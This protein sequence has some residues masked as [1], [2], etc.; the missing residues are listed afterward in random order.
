MKRAI[1]LLLVFTC[2]FSFTSIAYAE[3]TEVLDSATL[4]ESIS[5]DSIK[6]EEVSVSQ[7]VALKKGFSDDVY[8]TNISRNGKFEVT[9]YVDFQEDKIVHEYADGNVVEQRLSDVV[10]ITKTAPSTDDELLISELSS[11][12][13]YASTDYITNEP[14]YVSATGVQ[15]VLSGAAYYSGYRAMGY[16]GGYYY[17]P[18]TYG[19]LQRKN[20]G[21]IGTYYSHLFSFSA[22]TTIGTAASVIVAFFTSSGVSLLLSLATAILGAIVD[23]ITFDWRVRFEVKTYKWSYRIRL[24]SNTG[25]IIGEEYRTQDYWKGYNDATGELTYNYRGS[26]YDDGFPLSNAEMIKANIDRYL[27][28][29][30]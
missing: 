12:E 23:V 8:V 4:I 28:D 18:T 19:Y 6:V 21:A 2:L 3:N 15:S 10:T 24:N 13:P 9:I 27:E 17:A 16:R 7:I 22:G 26:A 20:S 1:S 11:I 5:G 14:L 29:Q 30:L 25:T